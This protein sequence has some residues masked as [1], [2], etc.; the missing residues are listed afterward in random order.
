MTK[1]LWKTLCLVG[2]IFQTNITTAQWGSDWGG[3]GG[4]DAETEDTDAVVELGD[5]TATY[6]DSDDSD[7]GWGDDS[8]AGWGG[9]GGGSGGTGIQ[10]PKPYKFEVAEYKRFAPPYDT[11]REVIFYTGVVEDYDCLECGTDSLYFRAKKYLLSY[12]GK[13]NLK[14]FITEDKEM[15]KIELLV[16]RPMLVSVNKNNKV[17]QGLL[18]YKVTLQFRDA[19]YKYQFGY[20]VHEESMAGNQNRISRTY[21]EYY[22]KNKKGVM[23][24]DRYLLAADREVKEIVKGLRKALKEPYNPMEAGE[25]DW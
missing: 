16:R 7:A 25:D 15:E 6:D 11:N 22:R 10:D 23:D 12:F 17:Q 4:S 21:H 9:D 3:D 20:F 2:L 19:R 5:T 8:D 14:S 18:E 24:S 13:K 1:Y